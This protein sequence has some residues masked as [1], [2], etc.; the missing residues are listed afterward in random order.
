[1]C[2]EA[3]TALQEAGGQARHMLALADVAHD[4]FPRARSFGIGHPPAVS[5]STDQPAVVASGCAE[6][7]LSRG[8]GRCMTE[9]ALIVTDSRPFWD[10]ETQTNP[11]PAPL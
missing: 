8:T 11:M 2:K 5:P 6:R 1:M 3:L 10:S 9:M 7:T 4:A